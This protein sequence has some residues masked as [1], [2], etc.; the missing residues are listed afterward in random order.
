MAGR[1][2]NQTSKGEGVF[3]KTTFMDR[4]V[5]FEESRACI[6]PVPYTTTSYSQGT[7]YAPEE[8]MLNW[9]VE[10]YD[11]ELGY[12]PCV[13]GIYPLPEREY[14]GDDGLELIG[15][16]SKEL[17]KAKKFPVFL[18]GDQALSIA[19][20]K[21]AAEVFGDL[22]V[23]FFDAHADLKDSFEDSKNSN[24]SVVRRMAE[25]IRT[26]QIGVRS[27][28]SEELEE[29]A[30]RDAF[31]RITEKELADVLKRIGKNVYIS[32]D[33]D[34]FDPSIMPAT[35]MPEP[36]GMSW[37]DVLGFIR[38]ITAGRN[39]VGCDITELSPIQ[40]ISAY[41]IMCAELAYKMIGIKFEGQAK[42]EGWPFREKAK[43]KNGKE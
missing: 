4:D 27:V 33:V 24:M 19:T 17:F 10:D 1:T 14:E 29:V 30:K 37:G 18:G 40:G 28:G 31:N 12:S 42:E 5:T 15:K 2:R 41:P 26:V 22:T 16:V 23:V 34:V 25:G 35:P 7:R 13:A 21:A 20:T 9:N 8:I 11:L 36:N 6:V 38:R 3:R 43:S 32:I 39:F